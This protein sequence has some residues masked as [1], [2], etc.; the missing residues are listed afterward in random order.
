MRLARRECGGEGKGAELG[1]STCGLVDTGWTVKRLPTTRET[2]VLSLGRE[3]LLEKGM[4]THS[5]I[6]VSPPRKKG[7]QRNIWGFPSSSDG[8][9]SAYKAEDLDSIP[10]LG[11]SP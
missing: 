7:A 10:G 8:K 4:A 1:V 11:R 3:D 6:L 9:A 2:W 5:S